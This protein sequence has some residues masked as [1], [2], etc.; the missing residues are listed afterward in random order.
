MV[1][2]KMLEKFKTLYFEEFNVRLSDEVAL[3]MATDLLN[4]MKILVWPE[5]K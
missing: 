2:K 3:K 1:S 4:L 5:S